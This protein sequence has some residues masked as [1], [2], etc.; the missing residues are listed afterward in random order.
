VY[1]ITWSILVASSQ[2]TVLF[3]L[4]SVTI[5]QV[6]CVNQSYLFDYAI[7]RAQVVSQICQVSPVLRVIMLRAGV[8]TVWPLKIAMRINVLIIPNK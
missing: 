6:Y 5:S 8:D 4:S 3:N 1:I 2:L 7:P